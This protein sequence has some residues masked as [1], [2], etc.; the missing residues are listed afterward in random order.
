MRLKRLWAIFDARNREF[1]RD[2]AAFGWN[3]LFPFLI[4]LGFGVI[5]K[6]DYQS[7]FKVGLFPIPRGASLQPS[8]DL[9]PRSFAT[10]EAIDWVGFETRA[11]GMD[12]LKHHQI[13]LLI[14]AGI[15]PI[16]YWVS[17]S[18]P[19]GAIVE[20]LCKAL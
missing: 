5:F 8:M 18:S 17:D 16:R 10:F 1:F 14:E 3:F 19:S 9:L 6:G 20:R 13:D 4:I 12:K 7:Q 2:R 11:L 15:Q